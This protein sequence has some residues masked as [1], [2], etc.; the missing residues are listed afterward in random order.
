MLF[1]LLINLFFISIVINGTISDKRQIATKF[2][3]LN[4]ITFY[5]LF[6][7]SF[8]QFL[9]LKFKHNNYL[10]WQ[11]LIFLKLDYRNLM[12]CAASIKICINGCG[13][14]CLW[15]TWLRNLNFAVRL[16]EVWVR[17]SAW[18][19]FPSYFFYYF[20]QFSSWDVE[21]HTKF[22]YHNIFL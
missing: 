10:I 20:Y 2:Y 7:V 3:S 17:S 1:I 11:N 4:L 9:L 18:A 15:E 8:W 16:E 22:Q 19:F 5:Y 14:L 6:L 12:Y 21:V 13:C